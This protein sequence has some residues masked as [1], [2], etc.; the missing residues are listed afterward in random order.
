MLRRGRRADGPLFQARVLPTQRGCQR[1]GLAVGRRVGGAVQR[2]RAKRLLRECFRLERGRLGPSVDVVLI[3]K[4]DM[5]GRG[6]AEVRDEF[7]RRFGARGHGAA[8]DGG[9]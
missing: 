8:A 5:V 9:R 4:A 6:L 1:L 3:A 2:N 7:G